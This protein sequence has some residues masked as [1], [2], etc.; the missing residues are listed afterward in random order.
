MTKVRFSGEFE[1]S[2]QPNSISD[3]Q[4][5]ALNDIDEILVNEEN[6]D[7]VFKKLGLKMDFSPTPSKRRHRTGA[8]LEGKEGSLEYLLANHDIDDMPGFRE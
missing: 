8:R 5:I 4:N 7:A 6:T 1:L 3:A 2:E